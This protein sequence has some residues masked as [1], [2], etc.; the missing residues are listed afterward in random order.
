MAQTVQELRGT[1]TWLL[2]ELK[3]TEREQAQKNIIEFVLKELDELE[4]SIKLERA[5][6]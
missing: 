2:R 3:D 6:K 4:E 1:L 5:A